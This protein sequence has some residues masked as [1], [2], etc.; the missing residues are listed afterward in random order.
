MFWNDQHDSISQ[1]DKAWIQLYGADHQQIIDT[2]IKAYW[3]AKRSASLL[4]SAMMV[5]FYR[6][7]YMPFDLP[8][9]KKW[10]SFFRRLNRL[11]TQP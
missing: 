9:Q 11:R 1:R 5:T 4:W 10:T 8:D 7:H 6:T 2:V 3:L